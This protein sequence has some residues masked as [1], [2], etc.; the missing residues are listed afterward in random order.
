MRVP[1]V[2][3][4]SGDKSFF[5]TLKLLLQEPDQRK[6]Q[7]KSGI[8]DFPEEDSSAAMSGRIP[9]PKIR[10]RT[11]SKNPDRIFVKHGLNKEK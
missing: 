11:T 6:S 1:P 3:S 4:N 10:N 8:P 9:N 2:K 7:V 5:D